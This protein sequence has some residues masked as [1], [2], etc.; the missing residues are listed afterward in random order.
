MILEQVS[1]IFLHSFLSSLFEDTYVQIT[2]EE[3]RVIILGLINLVDK[4]KLGTRI[5]AFS[6]FL[7][8]A[9]AKQTPA[10]ET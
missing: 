7:L 3:Y 10:T 6:Y 9:L 8:G 2:I 1:L 5:G 4:I